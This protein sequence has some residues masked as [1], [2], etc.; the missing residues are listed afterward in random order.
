M[1]PEDFPFAVQ[2]SNT[3]NWK[4]TVDDFELAMA[5]EPEGCFLLLQGSKR[6]GIAT[7]ASFERVGWLGN[8][9]VREDC[10]KKNAGRLLVNHAL[11]YLKC[12]G[13]S[14]IGLYSYTNLVAFYEHF[15]FKT[16]RDFSVLEGEPVSPKPKNPLEGIQKKF[17][18]N[19]IAFDSKCFG[20]NRTKLLERLFFNGKNLCY[21]LIDNEEVKGFAAAKLYDRM[22]EIGPLVCK[23]NY[24]DDAELLLGKLLSKLPGFKVSICLPRNETELLKHL[25]TLGFQEAFNVSRMFLGPSMTAKCIYSPESLERG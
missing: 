24:V 12:K 22:A 2:L 9:I 6:A 5:L 15:G 20:A 17:V 11:E 10:R 7:T 14:T 13:V 3:M 8:L 21:G 4:M 19:L 16:D 1:K 23:A 18:P 25:F